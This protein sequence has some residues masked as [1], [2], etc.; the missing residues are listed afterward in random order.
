MLTPNTPLRI[1]YLNALAGIGV[2][3][4]AKKIPKDVKIPL[5]FIILNAQLLKRTEVSKNS[6][7]WLC[8]INV[9]ITYNGV[10]GFA[11][12]VQTEI[13]EQAVLTAIEGGITVPG[14]FVKSTVLFNSL[15]MDAETPTQSIER[16]IITYQHWLCQM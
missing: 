13:V 12:P 16:R 1:A 11:S 7:E 15:S 5:N 6:W 9:D 4:Y 10:T 14:F 8:A 2:P 3:V